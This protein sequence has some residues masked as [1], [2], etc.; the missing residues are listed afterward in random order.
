MLSTIWGFLSN[1][2]F[3]ILFT[4]K[5]PVKKNEAKIIV[6]ECRIIKRLINYRQRSSICEGRE[7]IACPARNKCPFENMLLKLWTKAEHWTSSPNRCWRL[8]LADVTMS[9]PAF[10]NTFVGRSLFLFKFIKIITTKPIS[11]K[12]LWINNMICSFKKLVKC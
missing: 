10:A 2:A 3:L 12:F 4:V 5:Q 9:S 7:F 8:Q 11:S 1:L 6:K